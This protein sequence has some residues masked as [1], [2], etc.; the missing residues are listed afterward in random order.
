MAIRINKYGFEKFWLL[1]WFA[2]NMIG[3]N[4]DHCSTL[5]KGFEC[6]TRDFQ[7]FAIDS[8]FR[9]IQ[10]FKIMNGDLKKPKKRVFRKHNADYMSK[11]NIIKS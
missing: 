10:A 9:D 2:V 7:K 4:A 8:K 11:H 3:F 6:S 1:Y 5:K